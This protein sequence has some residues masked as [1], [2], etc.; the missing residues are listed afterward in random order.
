MHPLHILFEQMNMKCS[1][2]FNL[3]LLMLIDFILLFGEKFQVNIHI[4][5]DAKLSIQI[6]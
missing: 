4:E 2:I 5:I 3:N 6:I 1:T